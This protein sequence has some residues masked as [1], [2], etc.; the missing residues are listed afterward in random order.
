MSEPYDSIRS[1]ILVLGPFSSVNKAYSMVLHVERQRR[2]NLEYA[3]VG[4]NNA[5]NTRNMEYKSNTGHKMYH[6]KK[7]YIENKH[8]IC[9]HCSKPRHNKETCV[10][11][12]GV[13][14][15]YRDLNEQ[16]K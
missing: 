16:K 3:D 12:H 10:K 7:S 1:Q 13:P 9:E 5:M 8:M 2:V 14:K 4:E 15:W 11:L 6:K